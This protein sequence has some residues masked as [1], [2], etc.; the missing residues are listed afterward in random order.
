MLN[1][2][3]QFAG[4][5]LIFFD[6]GTYYI[7][8]TLRIP[9]GSQVAGEAWSVI[10]G[11]GAKFQDENNPKVMVQAGAPWTRGILEITDII[12]STVGPGRL[13]KDHVLILDLVFK[14]PGAILVEWNV[15]QPWDHQGGAG[16]WDTHFR[17]V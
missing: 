10:L 7:T 15:Q 5:K 14:A 3:R 13:F 9:T 4:C 12:F 17:Y 1:K 11:G 6:A 16:M 2:F 8:D